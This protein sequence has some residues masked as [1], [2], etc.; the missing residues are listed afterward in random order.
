MAGEGSSKPQKKYDTQP[1]FAWP[2]ARYYMLSAYF[3]FYNAIANDPKKYGLENSN[4]NQVINAYIRDHW[5]DLD[6]EYHTH[7]KEVQSKNNVGPL[8]CES[9]DKDL[10]KYQILNGAEGYNVISIKDN[11]IEIRHERLSTII[12]TK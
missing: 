8:K 11:H 10:P 2:P 12:E 7:L 5:E 6:A 9:F 4:G 1:N 3:L